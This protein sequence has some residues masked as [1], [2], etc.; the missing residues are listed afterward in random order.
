MEDA[1]AFDTV[2]ERYDGDFTSRR[3]GGWLRAAV[4]RRLGAAFR[5][6]D[7][8]LELGC[9]TGEDALWLARRGVAVT[10][11]DVSPG[12][13]RVAAAKAR[14]AGLADRIE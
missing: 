12:M 14:A 11:T 10:A 6:G 4:W 8:A 1:T 7:R 2:A 13:L 5:P 3:L 9:G